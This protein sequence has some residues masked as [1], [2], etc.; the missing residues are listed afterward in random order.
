MSGTWELFCFEPHSHRKKQAWKV[1][2]PLSKWKVN[3]VQS[4]LYTKHNLKKRS[5][6]PLLTPPTRKKEEKGM[7]LHS[8]MPLHG[9]ILFSKIIGCRYFAPSV[10]PCWFML[11]GSSSCSA[12]RTLLIVLFYLF[13]YYP[14]QNLKNLA[15]F[16]SKNK[17]QQLTT[18]FQAL[19]QDNF[20]FVFNIC[21]SKQSYPITKNHVLSTIN[22]F[23]HCT[24]LNE[25]Y[26]WLWICGSKQ[27]N[28]I[29]KTM[30]WTLSTTFCIA[31]CSMK[32][33]CGFGYV[34]QNN[35]TL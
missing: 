10:V 30:F 7:P 16:P 21:L 11:H 4:T 34:A 18:H 25:R 8:T 35:Q 14:K 9:E 23:L 15:P 26:L 19:K 27:S 28:P 29:T 32:G 31:Q 12:R 17:Y 2:C 3:S 5:P 33:I 20:F 13:Y 22:H 6:N 24:M 1:E